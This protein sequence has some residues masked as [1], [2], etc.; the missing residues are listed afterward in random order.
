VFA[1][2]SQAYEVEADNEY[3][4]RGNSAVMKCEV[5]SFVADF[6][7]VEMWTDSSGKVYRPNEDY[8]KWRLS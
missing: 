7:Y 2:V 5:P 8:G 1:V 6:V 4:I 3:V